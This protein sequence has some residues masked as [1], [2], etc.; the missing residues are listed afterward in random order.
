VLRAVELPLARSREA[1]DRQSENIRPLR[2]KART[3]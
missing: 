2:P 3:R 1:D